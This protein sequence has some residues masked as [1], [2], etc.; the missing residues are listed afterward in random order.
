MRVL[1]HTDHG[2][3]AL[4]DPMPA[5]EPLASM[6][7]DELWHA[8]EVLSRLMTEAHRRK[9]TPEHFRKLDVARMVVLGMYS[10]A[11]VP[12]NPPSPFKEAS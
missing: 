10:T 1:S 4:P 11:P 3:R 6:G 8:V 5:V 12:V 2:L 7:R 9:L